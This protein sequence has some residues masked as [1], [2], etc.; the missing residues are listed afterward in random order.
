[1]KYIRARDKHRT[2]AGK[3]GVKALVLCALA[4]LVAGLSA[5]AMAASGNSVESPQPL[6]A[7]TSIF[8]PFTCTTVAVVAGGDTATMGTES[9]SSFAAD[10]LMLNVKIRPPI[11]IPFRPVIRS[12]FRPAWP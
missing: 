3:A 10:M 1:M 9:E 12:P 7:V 8:D 11:R 2:S 6:L 4:V 5:T